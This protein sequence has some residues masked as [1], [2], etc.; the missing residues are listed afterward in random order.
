MAFAK[1]RCD[2]TNIQLVARAPGQ[3]L[4][5]IIAYS[6]V[7][8]RDMLSTV[9]DGLTDIKSHRLTEKIMEPPLLKYIFND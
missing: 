7:G 4:V 2:Q 8:T 1:F 9:L 6:L 5:E 3:A